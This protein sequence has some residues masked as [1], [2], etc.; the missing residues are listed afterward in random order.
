MSNRNTPNL[1]LLAKLQQMVEADGLAAVSRRLDVGR[2]ALARY[3]ANFYL[4]TSTFRGIEASLAATNAP[5]PKRA[6]R[7]ARHANTSGGR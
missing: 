1:E 3:G 6:A 5:K 7:G 4:H 2:E